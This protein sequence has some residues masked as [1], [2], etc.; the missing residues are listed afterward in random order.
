MSMVLVA[1]A[2]LVGATPALATPASPEYC[3]IVLKK[4]DPVTRTSPEVARSCAKDAAAVASLVPVASVRLVRVYQNTNWTGV[5]VD[6]WGQDG[7]C[8]SAG[9]RLSDLS[10]ANWQ[11]GGISSY[12]VYNAC[13]ASVTWDA[14]GGAGHASPNHCFDVSYVGAG[15]ND[16]VG[17]IWV[18]YSL[19]CV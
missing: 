8:D 18:W 11:V 10:D 16:R 4:V 7:P 17:A 5:W 12:R 13:W 6:V 1:S 2:V 9:Y 15:F 14:T 3:V 19:S